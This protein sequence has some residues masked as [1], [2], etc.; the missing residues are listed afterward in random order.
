[1][2]DSFRLIAA[3][4]GLADIHRSERMDHIDANMMDVDRKH[5]TRPFRLN[6]GLLLI[7]YV[8]IFRE[9]GVVKLER[10]VQQ[11]PGMR[12]SDIRLHIGLMPFMNDI[13]KIDRSVV[14][15]A[16][17][18]DVKNVIDM[19]HRYQ[20]FVSTFLFPGLSYVRSGRIVS[21]QAPFCG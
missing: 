19:R 12:I 20:S 4:D 15:N 5:F 14:R 6:L 7:H 10:T 21:V 16:V 8:G 2:G 9:I 17:Y 11:I 3:D 1:M 18:F 13:A